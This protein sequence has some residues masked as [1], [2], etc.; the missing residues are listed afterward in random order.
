[1]KEGGGHSKQHLEE[2]FC[3]ERGVVGGA[4]GRDHHRL[5]IAPAQVARRRQDLGPPLLEDTLE[6]LGLLAYL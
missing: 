5:Q 3:V 2:V 6:D 1:V 4:T